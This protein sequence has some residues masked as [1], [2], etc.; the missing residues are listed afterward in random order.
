[1]SKDRV[2]VESGC[3]IITLSRDFLII[4]LKPDIIE[5]LKESTKN[6]HML[7]QAVLTLL[8]WAHHPIIPIIDILDAMIE[9][10]PS[11]PGSPEL[12]KLIIKSI[13]HGGQKSY[14][15]Y[16]NPTDAQKLAS[17]IKTLISSKF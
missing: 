10:V 3:Q 4:T 2:Q 11:P 17:E 5:K 6:D 12:M 14:E 16:L 9:A 13:Y 15:V 7:N 1:M 8:T